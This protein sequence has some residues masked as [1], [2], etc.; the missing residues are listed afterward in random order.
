MDTLIFGDIPDQSQAAAAI[1]MPVL[2]SPA[3]A[4]VLC[5]AIVILVGVALVDAFAPT[6]GARR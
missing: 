2:I 3:T 4:Q 1:V 6:M 5:V